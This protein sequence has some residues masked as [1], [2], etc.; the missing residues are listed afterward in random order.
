MLK[1]LVLLKGN[2]HWSL[3]YFQ[4]FMVLCEKL[5]SGNFCILVAE[6]S[7]R[8]QSNAHTGLCTV[9]ADRMLPGQQLKT[10]PGTAVSIPVATGSLVWRFHQWSR[11]CAALRHRHAP[12][13]M[14][15]SLPHMKTRLVG[16]VVKSALGVR[17]T[18]A[19]T[20][21]LHS[22]VCWFF[23]PCI[24]LFIWEL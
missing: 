5:V 17:G 8:S 3:H 9:A 11:L 16:S 19:H 18:W 21:S 13:R 22:L 14:P 15:G 7:A 4:E 2:N 6:A 12:L 10:R 1:Y 20:L 24:S 23:S